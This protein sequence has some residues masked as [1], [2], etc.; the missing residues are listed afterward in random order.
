MDTFPSIEPVYTISEETNPLSKKTSFGDGYSKR[1]RF[2]L[3]F[4][5]PQ[6]SIQWLVSASDASTINLFLKQHSEDGEWFYWTPPDSSSAVKW[7]CDEWTIEYLADS[8]VRV[9]ATFRQ[10]FELIIPQ[11]TPV[12][13]TCLQNELCYDAYFEE[14]VDENYDVWVSRLPGY[15]PGPYFGSGCVTRSGFVFQVFHSQNYIHVSKFQPS[16]VHIW[17]KRYSN[18]YVT[19][20]SYENTNGIKIVD[21]DGTGNLAIAWHASQWTFTSGVWSILGPGVVT[22]MLCISQTSGSIQWGNLFF[23]NPGS[24]ISGDNC[25]IWGSYVYAFQ[26][27]L[28]WDP[29][30]QV[31]KHNCRAR[32][33][34]VIDKDGNFAGPMQ[35]F[36]S[37]Y[38]PFFDRPFGVGESGLIGNTKYDRVFTAYGVFFAPSTSGIGLSTSGFRMISTN[39][40][41]L[42]GTSESFAGFL[43][44]GQILYYFSGILGGYDEIVIIGD[45]GNGIQIIDHVR[46]LSPGNKYPVNSEWP[47]GADDGSQQTAPDFMYREAKLFPSS[48]LISLTGQATGINNLDISVTMSGNKV[49]AINGILGSCG[50][51]TQ[52]TATNVYSMG[53]DQYASIQTKYDRLVTFGGKGMEL[54]IIGM[55]RG[56]STNGQ[57]RTLPVGNVAN[58][59][60][61]TY[62][63]YSGSQYVIGVERANRLA[64]FQS[65]NDLHTGAPGLTP[66]GSLACPGLTAFVS[67]QPTTVEDVTSSFNYQLYTAIA[68]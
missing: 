55:K 50:V 46:L 56:M 21:M 13:A 31:I 33:I 26:E 62:V 53:A 61:N 68:Q 19:P 28:A 66:F 34:T 60:M 43:G 11:L 44:N 18:A 38:T 22:G 8:L 10:V 27:Y 45:N 3:N 24:R 54:T 15:P 4:I 36:G 17:T 1:I 32:N 59:Q 65:V 16:G 40:G 5:K 52:V 47:Q 6:W 67:N 58:F 7:R 37:V 20:I 23:S 49:T 63:G 14:G 2:G 30:K 42:G 64:V 29:Y 9:N 57:T 41:G 35:T 48:S 51:N 12:E 25:L 39:G